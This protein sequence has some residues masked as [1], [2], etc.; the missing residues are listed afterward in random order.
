MRFLRFVAL[1][2]VVVAA[3]SAQLVLHPLST[4]ATYE[5]FPPQ[6]QSLL[7]NLAQI[8]AFLWADL[9]DTALY[10]LAVATIT[11]G[12]IAAP[13]PLTASPLVGRT[14][15][16]LLSK[17]RRRQRV[18]WLLATIALLL[19]IA[20]ALWPILQLTTWQTTVAALLPAWVKLPTLTEL[21]ALNTW[22]SA[23][24]WVIS[25]VLFFLG[26]SA[27]P[28]F[29][30]AEGTTSVVS[31]RLPTNSWPWL[32]LFLLG[33]GWLYSWQLTTTPLRVEPPVAQVGLFVHNWLRIGATP[34]L[35]STSLT[36]EPGLAVAGLGTTATA[37]FYALT[38]DLLL[39]TRLAGLWG[40]ALTIIATWLL[41]TE[42]FARLVSSSTGR[43]E[44]QGQWPT[45]IAVILLIFM[46]PLLLFSRLP[47]LLEMVAWGCLG[48]WALLRGLRT[49][50]YL[51]MGL[52]GVA[53]G[54]SALMYTP[55]LVFVVTLLFWWLGYGLVRAG[56]LPHHLQVH[57]PA[58]QLRS[59]FLL[60]LI[61]LALV[62]LP[63]LAVR[64]V[65]PEW[66]AALGR[67]IM[68]QWQP[69]LLAFGY[70]HDL[71]QLSSVAVPLLHALLVPIL[72]LALGAL[73]F[74][75]DRRVSW[76]LLTWLFCSLL[77]G[78]AFGPTAPHGP[79]LLPVLPA[80]AL[81]L[82]VG[83][84]RFRQTVWVS[85]GPWL[86]N[87]VNYLLLGL[88]LWVGLTN[89]VTY[90]DFAKEQADSVSALGYELRQLPA[91]QTATIVAPAEITADAVQLRFLTNEWRTPSLT[92]VTFTTTLP[93]N[94]AAG[95]ILL[96]APAD[97]TRLAE[98]QVRY[99]HGSLLVRRDHRVN[100]LLYRYTLPL[101]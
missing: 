3:Y 15:A 52:S 9:Q 24:L 36:L 86:H 85:A 26:C 72:C 63:T 62:A 81:T 6:F 48:S 71:S 5:L 74:T 88:L 13:W 18:G 42:L 78:M 33:A 55:G 16:L 45:L 68:A 56:W 2:V 92:S 51:A 44:D 23:Q 27:F 97:A 65:D 17:L 84:D 12:L 70:Q 22:L 77:G 98:A 91:G 66:F 4:A 34:S 31:A 101:E 69:T 61:G 83:L 100:R 7:P 94:L 89:S 19:V 53:L 35:F 82:A 32:L 73:V 47:V 58:A 41:A 20:V 76:L 43:A 96:I 40:A 64:G 46:L 95:T 54:L 25:L 67:Q 10:L 38:D 90:Y 50:D 49:G 29:R 1:F 37:F 99:P 21:P 30:P 60:W 14:T 8:R 39:S 11:Y 87:F 79:A 80:L 93:A 75:F 57:L 59:Y 28:Q